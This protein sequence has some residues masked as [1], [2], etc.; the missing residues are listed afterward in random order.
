MK[1]TRMLML[2]LIC[3]VE[4]VGAS[5]AKDPVFPSRASHHEQTENGDITIALTGASTD[6]RIDVFNEA[7]EH[8]CKIEVPSTAVCAAIS[9]TGEKIG[10]LEESFNEQEDYTIYRFVHRRRQRWF[11]NKIKFGGSGIDADVM[12]YRELWDGHAD[13]VYRRIAY[14]ANGEML[15]YNDL[16]K[17]AYHVIGR[18]MGKDFEILTTNS[19]VQADDCTLFAEPLGEKI[20][21]YTQLPDL[22]RKRPLALAILSA[23][24]VA[25]VGGSLC[26]FY[27]K[28]KKD[29][30][31]SSSRLM[32]A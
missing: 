25:A 27:K 18:T 3:S 8:V 16:D 12:L 17:Q 10:W 26:Y 24:S 1:S 5:Y 20:L 29:K 28:K 7:Q 13:G 11:N 9:P 22:C 2:G 30:K 4:A 21:N 23:S 31:E 6:K 15:T 19:T 32:A 14:D